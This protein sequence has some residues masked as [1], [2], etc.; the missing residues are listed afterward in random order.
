M[1]ILFAMLVF[2]SGVAGAA[3]FTNDAAYAADQSWN[4]PMWGSPAAAPTSG[5]DYV[6]ANKF[7]TGTDW[8]WGLGG[9]GIFAGD[10]LKVLSG[11]T[12]VFG[13]GG[14][15]GGT[16]I[17]DG[18][19]IQVRVATVGTTSVSGNMQIDSASDLFSIH[20][21][22]DIR[23]GISGSGQL[24][25][26]GYTATNN[27]AVTISGPDLGFSGTFKL[28]DAGA[29]DVHTPIRFNASYGGAN[30]TFKD[31]GKQ[32]SRAPVYQLINDIEFLTVRMPS[33]VDINVLTNL[34]EGTY[35]GAALIAAGVSTNYF[36]DLGG[37][38]TVL[39]VPPN[40]VITMNP[41]IPINTHTNWNSALWGDPAEVPTNGFDYVLNKPSVWLSMLGG[42]GPFQ[43]DAI[44][45]A[46]GTVF[47]QAGGGD[48]GAKMILAGG[49][50]QNRSIGGTT[51][52]VTGDIEITSDS[53]LLNISGNL[54]L[55][56]GLSGSGA[57]ML[58]AFL[59]GTQNA[60]IAGSDEGYTGT[61]TLM[62]SGGDN[63]PFDVT[64]ETS[65]NG[66]GLNYQGGN[67]LRPVIYQ[68][69]NDIGFLTVKMPA[70]TNVSVM[71]ELADGTYDGAA[72]AAAGVHSAF[73]HDLGGHILVGPP[74]FARWAGGWG[75]DIGSETDNHDGDWLD[76]LAEYGL[77]GDPTDPLDRGLV[78]TLG[79]DAGTLVYVHAQR[80]DD[81]SLSYYLETNAD[82]ITGGAWVNTGYSVLATNVTGGLFDFVTN[83]VPT[84]A[85]ET[86]VRLRIKQQ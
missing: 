24:N 25:I 34:P 3:S 36:A 46:A 48:L 39:P 85:D 57:F 30:L 77:G 84:A 17:M 76:N 45:M 27:Y 4:M 2:T 31:L 78:P 66:A 59:D 37:T 11:H 69:T 22:L 6:Y 74:N 26:F 52:V 10:S 35:D 15:L 1:A 33:S 7:T 86:F 73:Y 21:D 60:V 41:G 44:T 5:N 29:D 42:N 75:V 56:V 68:L 19:T 40:P 28:K 43:G 55:D 71:V 53:Q 51:S 12:L 64:F 67:E 63:V 83:S 82:L 49:Q 20:G 80:T 18:G 13:G 81:P 70:S 54:K 32:L 9:R 16:L 50:W 72:L 38:L 14:S 47:F 61:F 62:N 58:G 8:I 79:N 23:A 65:F